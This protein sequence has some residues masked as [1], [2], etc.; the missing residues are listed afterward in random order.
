[1]AAVSSFEMLS[2]CVSISPAADGSEGLWTLNLKES[3]LS[4]FFEPKENSV[5]F[6]LYL[7]H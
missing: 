6:L 3:H 7:P 4:L 1:M 2:H 5:G